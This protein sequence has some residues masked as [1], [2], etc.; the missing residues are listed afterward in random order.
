[1]V[2]DWLQE[3]FGDRVISGKTNRPWPAHSPA[4]N[5]FW[6]WGVCLQEIRRLKPRTLEELKR[7]VTEF[8]ANLDPEEVLAATA[9]IRRRAQVCLEMGGRHFEH[10]MKK[11]KRR[12]S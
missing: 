7:V 10:R 12:E 6:L 8:C 1:M 4:P 2:Q 11:S 3:K 9:N 5:N